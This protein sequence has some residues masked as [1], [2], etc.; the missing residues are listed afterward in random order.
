M[1]N[2]LINIL[3]IED[4]DVQSE[5]IADILKNEGYNVTVAENGTKALGLIDQQFFDILLCDYYLPDINGLEVVQIA[6]ET[7]PKSIPILITCLNSVEIAIKG[8]R[9]GIHDYLVKPINFTELKKVINNILEERERFKNHKEKYQKL[10]KE[11][12]ETPVNIIIQSNKEI[13]TIKNDQKIN[14]FENIKKEDNSTKKFISFKTQFLDSL[15]KLKEIVKK[16]KLKFF[17]K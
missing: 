16:N 12:K 7:S 11:K 4:E 5:M 8:M 9:N 1:N 6:Q 15:Q 17:N 2:N 3:V 14:V 10:I 13:E